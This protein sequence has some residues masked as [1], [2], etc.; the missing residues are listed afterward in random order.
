MGEYKWA[1]LGYEYQLKDVNPP[2]KERIEVAK[3]I[4]EKSGHLVVV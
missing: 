2:T 4:F 1:E 3:S